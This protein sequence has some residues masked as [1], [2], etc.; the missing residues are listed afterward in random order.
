MVK[1]SDYRDPRT[2]LF[3]LLP[4]VFQ[5]ETNEAVFENTFNRFL[6]KPQIE[7]VDGFAGAPLE[8][9]ARQRQIQEPTPHRQAFQLQPLL[10]TQVGNI[11]HLASYVDILNEVERLGIDSCRLPLWGNA[12]KVNWAPPID[13]DKLV[14]FRDYWWFNGDDPTDPPQYI[15]IENPDF[16][17]REFRSNLVVRWEYKSGSTLY[18]VWSQ[19]RSDEI[20]KGIFSF[21]NDMRDLFR[22]YPHDV[23][24]IK[25]NHWFSL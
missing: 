2:N 21:K 20:S 3:E 11:N 8:N 19:G 25:F 4:E 17:I 9:A 14:N 12:V 24:L 16:N 22:I 15:T 18:F 5:S 13:I 10:F 1:K 23:F 6:S 7:L